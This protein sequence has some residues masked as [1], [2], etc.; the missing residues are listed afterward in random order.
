MIIKT[1]E[2]FVK[3]EVQPHIKELEHKDF[4]LTRKL[5]LQVGELGLLG[6][7][8]EEEYGGSAMDKI[9]S[10]LITAYFT[11]AGSLA[12]TMGC[13]TGI[14]SLPL[15]FFGNKSQKEKYLPALASGE[16]I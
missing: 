14:G 7:D 6:A 8:I 4:E 10:L 1:T 5:M 16:K 9:A 15:I 12:L 11:P 3:N 2:D 13:H